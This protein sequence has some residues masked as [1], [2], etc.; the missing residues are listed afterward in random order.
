MAPLSKKSMLVVMAIAGLIGLCVGLWA[1]SD[2]GIGPMPI[3]V[4]GI[5]C[6]LVLVATL[7][8]FNKLKNKQEGR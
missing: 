2:S 4:S 8:V 7:V 1:A 3:I 5:L 6:G